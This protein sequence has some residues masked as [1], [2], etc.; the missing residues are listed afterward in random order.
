MTTVWMTCLG[1]DVWLERVVC[2]MITEDQA[3]CKSMHRHSEH[4]L[5][6]DFGDLGP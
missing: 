4:V 2:A 5:A 3:A 6:S 1:S